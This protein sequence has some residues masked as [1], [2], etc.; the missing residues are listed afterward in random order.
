[1]VGIEFIYSRG[2][3]RMALAE[4]EQSAYWQQSGTW[5]VFRVSFGLFLRSCALQEYDSFV[6][7]HPEVLDSIKVPAEDIRT[8]A[9]VLALLSLA[10]EHNE[11]SFTSIKVNLHNDRS[12][13]W[14]AVMAM[15]LYFC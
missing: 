13:G 11:L 6:K 9:R 12:D 15:V 5:Y 3:S 7:K 10:S 4:L 1:M 2:M 8:K 14:H